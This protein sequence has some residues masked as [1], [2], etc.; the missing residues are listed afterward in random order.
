MDGWS[1]LG[2]GGLEVFASQG[3]FSLSSLQ[4]TLGWVAAKPCESVMG[5][6]GPEAYISPVSENLVALVV[7]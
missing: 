4:T 1:L 2:F 3:G 5:Q 6:N 7:T